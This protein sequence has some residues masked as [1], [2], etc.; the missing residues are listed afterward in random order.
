MKLL[1]VAMSESI[2]TAR[3][4]ENIADNGW[5]IHLFPSVD[6]GIVHPKFRNVYVY[7]S[8]YGNVKNKEAKNRGLNV[9]SSL[10]AKTLRFL[11]KYLSPSYRE[12]Q[13]ANLIR[14]IK[15]DLIHSMETQHSGYLVSNVRS[16]FF[17]SDFPLWLHTNWG[18]DIYLFGRLKAH[19]AKI[20]ILLGQCQYYSCETERDRQLAF[21]CGFKGIAMPVFPNTGG[22]DLTNVRSLSSGCLPSE[23]KKIMLKGYQGWAGR[24]LC[25]IRALSLVKDILAG[26]EIVVYSVQKDSGVDIALELFEY[27]TGI[28]TSII[29]SESTHEDILKLHGESRIS[30]GLSISDAISTSMLEAM[31]MGSFPVQSWTAATTEWFD[32]GIGG[33]SVP[34]EDPQVIAEALRKA[35][36]DDTLVDNAMQINNKTIVERADKNLLKQ[37]TIAL[38]TAVL[39]SKGKN[40]WV[41][42]Y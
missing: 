18:S 42:K 7:H 16:S 17:S 38:Y 15:P 4:L 23:R 14:K 3:W 36:A 19:Q 33:I 32:E 35:L 13:L 9:L 37:K 39:E 31:V 1:V 12:F 26:Y 20:R 22:F 10:L 41:T 30:I 24:A 29:P 25:G 5:E 11:I 40:A 2:H 27:D 8:I 21:E 28:K 6:L 34:P